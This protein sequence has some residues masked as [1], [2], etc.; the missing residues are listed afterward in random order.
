MMSP[1]GQMRLAAFDCLI[2]ESYLLE[3]EKKA[4]S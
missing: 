2:V 4:D 1:A 3:I